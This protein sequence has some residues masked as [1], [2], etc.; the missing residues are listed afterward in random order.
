MPITRNEVNSDKFN[1]AVILPY[2]LRTQDFQLAMQDI[3]DLFY[4]VN[5]ILISRGLD[6]FDDMLR[7]AAMSGMMSD[8]LTAAV[9]K[10]SRA[11]VENAYHNGHPDLLLKGRYKSD[12][13]QSGK[14]GVEVK[15]TRGSGA[16]DS[17]GARK[18]W[19]CVF[20]YKVDDETEPA[21][22]RAPMTFTKVLLADLDTSDFRTNERGPLGTR[23]ASPNAEGM[24][25]LR[26]NWVYADI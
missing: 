10:H 9:A 2:E 25:K 22:D 14:Y 11:L 4:D 20:H 7:P 15:S 24:R 1:P 23:T 3:Y 17:H 18:A 16:V 5:K 21:V 26:E 6:R 13:V 8:A 12:A 19:L